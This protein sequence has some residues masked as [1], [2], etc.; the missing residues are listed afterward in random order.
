MKNYFIQLAKNQEGVNNYYIPTNQKRT[1]LMEMVEK[2]NKLAERHLLFINAKNVPQEVS[3][4]HE[5]RAKLNLEIGA[6]LIG[7]YNKL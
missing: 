1:C 5:S 7:Y 4:W 2:A 3:E 6:R